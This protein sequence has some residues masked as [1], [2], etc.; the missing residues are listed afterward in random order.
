MKKYICKINGCDANY[1]PEKGCTFDDN[2][3]DFIRSH[4]NGWCIYRT[5]YVKKN[6][7]EVDK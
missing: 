2:T 5:S 4:R 1:H 6:L 3:K 7:K